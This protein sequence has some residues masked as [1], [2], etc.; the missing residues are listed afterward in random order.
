MSLMK[1]KRFVRYAKK[2]LLLIKMII[3]DHCHYTGEFRGTADSVCN[4][5]YKTPKEIPIL[6]H[7]GS[8]YDITS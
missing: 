4:L 5:R 6:F 3:R 1:S 2:N 7:N 8:T